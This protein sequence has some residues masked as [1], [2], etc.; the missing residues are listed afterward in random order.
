MSYCFQN[1]RIRKSLEQAAK[2]TAGHQRISISD[3]V[4]LILPIPPPAEQQEIVDSV[5]RQ[6]SIID[7][8]DGE[9]NGK[10]KNAQGLRQSVLHHAFSGKLVSQDPKN[11]PASELLKRIAAEREQ[12]VREAAAKRLNGHKP[13]RVSKPRGKVAHARTKETDHGRI[14]D[15]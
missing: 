2:S 12:R 10:L 11:E 9:L 8:L 5:E 13:R 6:L 1:A 15:R 3:L 4:G 7:H 14:A